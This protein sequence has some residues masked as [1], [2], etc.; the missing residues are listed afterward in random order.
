[1]ANWTNILLKSLDKHL[2]DA[3]KKKI[4]GECGEQCPFTHLKDEKLLEI[5]QQSKSDRDF[6]DT[7][8]KEWRMTCENGQYYVVFDKCYC[9]LVEN[10]LKNTSESLCYCTLGNLERKFALGLDQQV[11]IH[12]LKTILKG[13]SECR[14]HIELKGKV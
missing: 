6:L 1:M 7:L 2:D 5:K 14:F 4:L 9:P 3:T 11:S 13:D 10:D 12:M 8:C